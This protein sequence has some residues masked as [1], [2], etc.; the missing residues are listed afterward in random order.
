MIVR[1]GVLND[2]HFPFE[3]KTAYATA[4]RL[5]ASVGIEHLFLNGDIGEFQGVSSW[6]VHPTEKNIHLV[7]EIAYMNKKFDDL[8]SIFPGVPVTYICGNH[9]YRLFR[10]IRDIAPQM[11]GLVPGCPQLL[12]FEKRPNWKFVDYGPTQLVRCGKSKLYLRHEP[13]GRGANH[14]KQTAEVSLVDIAYGHTHAYQTHSHRKFGPTPITTRAYSLG[15]LGD[16]T[17]SVFDY[18]GPKDSW[19]EGATVVECDAATG[20]YSLEF[21]DLRKFPVLYRGKKYSALPKK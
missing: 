17:R 11:W 12:Q 2:I 15:F 9:E 1:Y 6:P 5:L 18:R 20:D 10:F 13:L 19:V 8:C 4:V 16:R 21:I 7:A 3:N 14:A